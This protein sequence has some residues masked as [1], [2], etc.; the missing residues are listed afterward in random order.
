MKR[1]KLISEGNCALVYLLPQS[2]KELLEMLA[3]GTSQPFIDCL[4]GHLEVVIKFTPVLD[5][6]F[7]KK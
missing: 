5:K 1:C 3:E 2:R 4:V 6:V 7:E